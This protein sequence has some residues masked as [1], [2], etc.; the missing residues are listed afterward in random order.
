MILLNEMLEK[1]KYYIFDFDLTLFNTKT[2]SAL[3]YES[4]FSVVGSVYNAREL[5]AYMSEFLDLT[6]ARIQSPKGDY[7]AFENE[8][9][10]V[11]HQLMA[12]YSEP[13][14]DAMKLL[15]ILRENNKSISIVTNKDKVAVIDILKYH[16]LD[17]KMFDYIITCE[18]VVNRK[19]DPEALNMCIK[20]LNA[21]KKLVIYLG[22]SRND[23]LAANNAGIRSVFIQRNTVVQDVNSTYYVKTLFELFKKNT[24]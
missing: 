14:D 8:F 1:Y 18:D 17:E 5:D 24:I 15:S 19:P 3:A 6:Y 22:D 2:G 16:N 21:N 23:I 10:K 12:K 9:Y 13:Y 7:L 4:A 20:L 11:S